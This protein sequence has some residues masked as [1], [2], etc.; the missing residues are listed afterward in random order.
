MFRSF[1]A[2]N[3]SLRCCP[4]HRTHFQTRL[5]RCLP[6]L[7]R[8][9]NAIAFNLLHPRKSQICSNTAFWNAKPKAWRFT[10]QNRHHSCLNWAYPSQQNFILSIFGAPFFPEQRMKGIVFENRGEF[11]SR[12]LRETII[13]L[14]SVSWF[15]HEKEWRNSWTIRNA[16]RLRWRW[17]FCLE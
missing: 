10:N 3:P 12:S 17:S 16:L 13:I 11:L 9:T 1:H 4:Y 2:D 5:E 15:F 7:T 14:M 8:L 6:P